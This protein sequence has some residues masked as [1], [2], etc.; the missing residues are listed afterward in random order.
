MLRLARLGTV[1]ALL[2]GT[3]APA[4]AHPAPFTYLD[5]RVDDRS[6]EISLIAHAFD[7]A[8]DTGLARPEQL[9]QNPDL[10]EHGTRFA[11]LLR[12]R[13]TLSVDG[14]RLVLDPWTVAEALPE[15]QSIRLTT[16]ASV[17]S[18]PGVI[19]V[20]AH[21]FPYDTAHQTFV[22]FY[23][24]GA[25]SS[26]AILD[27]FARD[28]TYYAGTTAGGWAAVRLALP[29]AFTHVLTG[30]DH[31][32]IVVGLLL[33]GSARRQTITI[34]LGFTAG[35]L[36][37]AALAAFNIVSPPARLIDPA[38]ALAVV[39]IGADNL[40]A[41]GGRDVRAWMAVVIGGIH[42]FGFAALL[43]FL[44]LSRPA[45]IW[46]IGAVT[47]GVGVASLL[48]ALTVAAAV[49]AV[50]SRGPQPARALLLSGSI[51]VMALG[52]A[53]F[54]QRVFFPAFTAFPI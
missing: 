36:L 50:A 49:R 18:P 32:A 15:R 10:Q 1:L 2:T 14:R 52:V 48:L 16:R 9:L 25:I 24:R 22:N 6:L 44:G 5:I 7:V 45:L 51:A 20:T 40:M 28:T 53:W 19:A 3:V 29:Q 11:Q 34:A 31:I 46:S 8:H 43:R 33:I 21:L 12:E 30:L 23:D 17:P 27:A 47:I 13:L 42:G 41:A 38:L 54:A 4:A 39:Y 35:H 37:T 26:Q